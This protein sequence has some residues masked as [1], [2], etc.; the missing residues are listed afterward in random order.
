M[1]DTRHV[2]RNQP[3]YLDSY[4][5]EESVFDL[6][7]YETEIDDHTRTLLGEEQLTWLMDGLATSGATWQVLGQQVLMGRM[8]L[9]G[10]IAA[11]RVGLLEYTDL[12]RLK[13]IIEKEENGQSLSASEQTFLDA[14]RE[15]MNQEVKNLLDLPILPYNL[16]AWD[17]YTVER[18]ALLTHCR[19]N[20]VNL[21]VLAGDTHNAWASNLQTK[22]GDAVGVEF[23]TSSVTSPG[24]EYYLG[25]DT[26][27]AVMQGEMGATAIIPSLQYANMNDRGFMLLNFT[28]EKA[29][30]SWVFVDDIKA[31]SYS[32]LDART[33]AKHCLPGS[34]N[35]TLKR[36]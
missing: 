15:R 31:E 19:D 11:N 20:D 23:A 2:A 1:L 6:E 13:T 16:D 28:E 22:E 10:G 8:E 9:P 21:V 36:S 18:E 3:L 5:G 14:N 7:R 33:T 34:E 32:R 12:V 35:R 24:L 27:E 30:C 4:F 17:G 25:L 26:P 29:S